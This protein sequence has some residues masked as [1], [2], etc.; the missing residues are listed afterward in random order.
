MRLR[1][2]LKSAPADVLLEISHRIQKRQKQCVKN[3]SS[4]SESESGSNLCEFAK[5][6][7]LTENEV[8]VC[9]CMYVCVY[10]C[11]RSP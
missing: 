4:G 10:V 7:N 11:M 3:G 2:M 5:S 1:R 8:C 9:V 6:M